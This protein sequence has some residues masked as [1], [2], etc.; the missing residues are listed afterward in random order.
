[1]TF[2]PDRHLDGPADPETARLVEA[3]RK[4]IAGPVESH[5][6]KLERF[7]EIR[8]LQRSAPGAGRGPAAWR[9]GRSRPGCSRASSAMPWPG[10]G[11]THSS[12]IPEAGSARP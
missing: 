11:I 8:A 5:A 1:L 3:K 12:S 9:P 6:Q 2:N 4:A 10:A 7:H